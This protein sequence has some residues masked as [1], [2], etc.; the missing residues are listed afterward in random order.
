ML[1]I[2]GTITCTSQWLEDDR[3]WKLVP[4]SLP[5]MPCGVQPKWTVF[6]H[7]EPVKTSI[8]TRHKT[9]SRNMY[10]SAR[11]NI[12]TSGR[13]EEVLLQN[14]NGNVMEGSITTPY[15][16]REGR[17]ITPAEKCGGN[18][19]TT[20]RWALE[21]RLAIEGVIAMSTVRYGEMLLLSNG[22]HGFS[23]GVISKS[24]DR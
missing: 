10:D 17:W 21:K 5:S 23:F 1:S 9:T 6:L 24:T 3:S 12:R 13:A 19:G 20:R 18:L 15:F 7:P 16:W 22:V 8:L 14:E 11:G 2:K 4:D